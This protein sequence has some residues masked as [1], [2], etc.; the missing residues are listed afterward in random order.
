MRIFRLVIV[1]AV[2]IIFP[3]VS[4][5]YLSKGLK[6][7]LGA[8]EETSV[9][10]NLQPFTLITANGDTVA[11]TS[12]SGMFA[13]IASPEDST[14]Y[15][16]LALVEE[17]FGSRTDY[18]TLYLVASNHEG[19]LQDSTIRHVRCA[20]GCAELIARAYEG[21]KNA[22]II[23]DS[24]RVRGRYRIEDAAEMQALIKHMAVVLPIEKREKLELIR[25]DY[26]N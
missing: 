21:E 9:K 5:V 11:G 4:W 14:G 10:A 7:R 15:A 8:Q 23:D 13:I 24:L 17:Q 16:H 3:L 12:L 25:R 1:V 6:W 26:K 19:S 2:L 22:A 18:Q 20:D